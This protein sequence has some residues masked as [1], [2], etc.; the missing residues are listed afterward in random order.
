MVKRLFAVGAG[1][2]M[3][4]A[5][6][7]GALA[8]DLSSYPGMFVEDGTFNGFFVVGE[9]AASVDNLAMTDIAA[10]MKVAGGSG[11]TVSVEGDAWLVKSGTDGLEFSESFGPATHGVVDFLDDDDLAA[12]ADG[13]LSSSQGT[14][15]YEQFLHFDKAFINTTHAQD[16]DD[17]L[18]LYL[19]I[20]DNKQFAR[21]ELNFLEAA[22]SD[23]DAG[24]SF[25]LDDYKDKQLTMFGKTYDI[26]KA[27]T[28]GTS[29]PAQVTL[30]LMAGAVTATLNEGESMKY[31]I[32]GTEYDVSLVF[33]DS[34]SRA[35]F[36][37]N[38]ETTPLMDESD[39]ETLSDGTVIGLSDV[40]YQDYA[41]GIHSAS[42][43]LGADKIELQDDTINVSGSTDELK[44]ND[45]T[46]DGAAVEIVG[47]I[48]DAV[49]SSTDDGELEIDT[50]T[51]NMTAQED[52]FVAAGET[53]LGQ[54]E[55]DEKD[56]VFSQNWDIQFEGMDSAT[57]VDEIKIADTSGQKE[58]QLNF[59]NVNGD[60]IT[61]PLAYASGANLR[62][63]DQDDNL[64]LH[65]RNIAD[66]EYFILNDDTDEDSVTHVVQYKGADKFGNSDPK[67]KFKVLASGESIQRP[68]SFGKTPMA[69][70]KLSGTTYN[71]QNMSTTKG[72]TAS[73]DWW[74][75]VDG[76][77]VTAGQITINNNENRTS[78]YLV[79][80][81]GAKIWLT[82]MDGLNTTS[83]TSVRVNVSLID[84]NR[85]DDRAS[86]PYYIVKNLSFSAASSEVD[87]SHLGMGTGAGLTAPDDDSDNT[88]GYS[89]N[90]AYIHRNSPSGGGTSADSLTI[91]WPHE[92]RFVSAYVTSGATSTTS[93]ASG[94]MVAVEY[95]GVFTKLDSE[96]AD[97]TAQNLIVVGGPCVNTVAASLLGNPADCA[98]GFKAGVGRVKLFEHAN[99]NVAMLV[100]GYS[101]ADTRRLGAVFATRVADIQS[102]GGME[103]EVE[104]T[105]AADVTIGAPAPVAAAPA[106]AEPEGEA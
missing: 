7:M 58:Y 23:V 65:P 102:A 14:F 70:L 61:V 4:G 85:I 47:A 41:G 104:G 64:T 59:V 103:L 84:S 57:A 89:I 5:T 8:A 36:V 68:V 52:Y 97:A 79:A 34:S 31:T 50:I 106:P 1:A 45:E 100:A 81:G 90:G 42:F 73:D 25:T 95:S 39:T 105:T 63:G 11:T 77:A 76:G 43:F 29:N 69:T 92:E 87:F 35:K 19:K 72:T 48:L 12:L 82:D 40:L 10:N 26:V 62:F 22:E 6:A 93:T 78:N 33:T 80:R 67:I 96:I 37:I 56:L 30:T 27:V 88:Y 55:M 53:L 98:E 3:L 54:E 74:I 9:N 86:T 75:R 66:E 101:G 16:D 38:G 46:I 51:I 18:D 44:V 99:G 49:T 21:Y 24:E 60:A 71:V 17:V 28:G 2:T 83:S 20:P 15:D 32:K 91:D 13:K 94:D